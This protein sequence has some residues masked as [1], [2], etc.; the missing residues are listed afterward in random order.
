MWNARR[1]ALMAGA[2]ILAA[3]GCL[4]V[5][6]GA[7]SAGQPQT[8]AQMVPDNPA[9]HPPPVQPILYSHKLHLSLH[10]QCNDC[11][12]N[13]NPGNLMTF[14]NTST[15]MQ[16][17]RTIA[18]TQPQIQK[19]AQYAK[20]PEPIPWVRIYKVL[21]G[22]NWSHRPHLGAGVKCEACHGNVPQMDAMAEVTSVVTM[23]G[24][25]HCHE[26]TRAGTA[27]ETCH[28]T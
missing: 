5:R 19:L 28:K 26:I 2:Y 24:C 15:C 20:S 9:E 13:P 3:F 17:H 8:K 21:P 16:C 22:I 23:Y 6:I 25:L 27:C 10:L 1:A 12:S 4:G 7:Q 11:H 18:K 14:P